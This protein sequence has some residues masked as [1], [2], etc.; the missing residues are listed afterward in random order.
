[1]CYIA[2]INERR[3]SQQG[4]IVVSGR[5]IFKIKEHMSDGVYKEMETQK[6]QHA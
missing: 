4:I 1:M 3:S 5:G 2:K 6:K